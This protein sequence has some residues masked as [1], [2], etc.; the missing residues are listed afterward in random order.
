ADPGLTALFCT[1]D[2]LALG[3]LEAAR[4]GGRSVPGDLSVVGHDDIDEVRVTHPALT[5]VAVPS[6]EMTR[7][8]IELLLRALDEGR[9]PVNSLQL[10]RSTLI[11]R[12]SSGPA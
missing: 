6:R 11:V 2:I 12:A 10:L 9:P 7:Q 1:H 3:A 4:L 8:A 5:T